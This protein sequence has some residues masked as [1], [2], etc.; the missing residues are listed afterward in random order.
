M[1]I[2]DRD[3]V[4]AAL[5]EVWSAIVALAG[6]LTPEDWSRHTACPGWTVK[7]NYSHI[8]GTESQLLG[9]ETPD[10]TLPAKLPHVHNEL[11]LF[12]EK[13]V[14]H[15]RP[16]AVTDL[17]ADLGQVIVARRAQLAKMDQADFDAEAPTPAGPDTYGR[18]MRVRV[19]DQWFHEQDV[20]EATG[21]PGHLEGLAPEMA[22]E[23][24]TVALGYAVAKKAGVKATAS[25]RF[26]LT[27]PIAGRIDVKVTDRGRVVERLPG[28][29]TVTLRL[30]GERFLRIAGGRIAPE[31]R[32][33][34]SV[35][36]VGDEALGK[37]V[38]TGM[39]FII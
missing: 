34:G 7:D 9:R 39:A 1:T 25:V 38:I 17:L 6:E 18:L 14:E 31:D 5:D 33:D 20:R 16:R 22:L 36:M 2:V 28:E 15:Y 37:Q 12:N 27:G 3:R 11:G 23:E 10:V 21:K 19:M 32:I 8:V 30:P 13:W 29:P 24:V 35:E 4:V 26:E